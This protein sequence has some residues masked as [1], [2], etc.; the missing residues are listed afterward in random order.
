MNGVHQYAKFSE[1][2]LID[3]CARDIVALVKQDTIDLTEV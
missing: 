2:L 3:R 1:I